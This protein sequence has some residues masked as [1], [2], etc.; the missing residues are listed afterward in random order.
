MATGN[1]FSSKLRW[2]SL[3]KK[4]KNVD[5]LN[6]TSWPLWKWSSSYLYGNTDPTSRWVCVRIDQ[7]C[8]FLP[9]WLTNHSWI[10]VAHSPISTGFITI[11]DQS[12]LYLQS[13]WINQSWIYGQSQKDILL[14]LAGFIFSLVHTSEMPQSYWVGVTHICIFQNR[15]VFLGIVYLHRVF[16]KCLRIDTT[17]PWDIQ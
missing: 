6:F 3:E 14:P 10:P 12:Q 9:S 8:H 13:L 11:T 4:K 7:R 17:R 5:L 15:N 2:H 1:L 16:P